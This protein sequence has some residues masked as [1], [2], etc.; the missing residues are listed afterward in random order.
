MSNSAKGSR[1]T[2]VRFKTCSIGFRYSCE[3]SEKKKVVVHM[4]RLTWGEVKYEWG[5][6]CER[7]FQKLK[8]RLISA[9]V[10]RVPERGRGYTM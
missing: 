8:R 7:A 9:S 6:P 10:L 2:K 5:D 1:L 4:T 3:H